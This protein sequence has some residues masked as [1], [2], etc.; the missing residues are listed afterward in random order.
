[1]STREPLDVETFGPADIVMTTDLVTCARSF[2]F[3]PGDDPRK[4]ASANRSDADAIVA[5]LEDAVASTRKDAA[6][7]VVDD[8]ARR[9]GEGPPLLVRVNA[10]SSEFVKQD[11]EALRDLPL[12]GVVVPK[13]HAEDLARLDLSGFPVVALIEDARGILDAFQIACDARVVR[14]ALGAVDLATELGLRPY[15]DGLQLLHA[16]S[17][18]VVASAAAG[19]AAP[20]DTPF[21]QFDDEAGLRSECELARALGF[22]GKSCIHP[23]QVQ[24]VADVFAPS[25]E[26]L[27]WAA[28]IVQVFERAA[29]SDL[30]VTSHRGAM[31]DAPVV[32]RARLLLA[33]ATEGRKTDD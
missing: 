20:I 17:H 24:A 1:L 16:R 4:L 9:R 21:L 3:V 15:G 31:V 12:A 6:R 27:A 28:E 19:I 26:E 18:L 32:R 33:K 14:L 8:F 25:P 29:D 5:D 22:A 2:L 7:D 30:G 11:I 10:P 13:T 23:A